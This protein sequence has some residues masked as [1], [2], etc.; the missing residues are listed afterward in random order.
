MVE[1]TLCVGKRENRLH[2]V[3][4]RAE[5]VEDSLILW[6][7]ECAECVCGREVP[8]GILR[9]VLGCVYTHT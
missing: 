8:S 2:G 7:T 3:C 6:Q 5:A 9:D 4:A 1:I